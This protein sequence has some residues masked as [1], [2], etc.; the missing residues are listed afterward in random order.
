MT[1]VNTKTGK[2]IEKQ[3]FEGANPEKQLQQ[4]I[5]KHL[6][7]F[8]QCYHLKSFYKV[9]GG[10]IDCLALSE[11][12]YP[13]IIE[14]KHTKDE[15]ILNQII[16]Y[17]D[18]LQERS[19]KYEFERI[20]KENSET[21]TKMV[22]WSKIRL[23]CVAKEYTKWDISLIKHIDTEIE[24]YSYTYHKDELDIHLDP[25]INQYK[26]RR[27]F[28]AQ[29]SA[30]IKQI[31]LEDH[32]NKADKECKLLFDSLRNKIL[33]LGPNVTEG[34]APNYI[35]YVVKTTFAS[36]HVRKK[37]LIIHLR[38]NEEKFNDKKNLAK[39]ISSRKWSVTREF[40]IQ[41]VKQI[42]YA[43]SLI[44]QAYEFQE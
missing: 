30:T 14:F 16:F 31:T 35:K 3:E 12:G 19:T 38:V 13:S 18:W 9:P 7:K 2:V 32:R 24:C 27:S 37:H 40:K 29:N 5:E 41:D 23:I 44:K 22:D 8:F 4:V 6:N 21:G 20:V 34:Y 33:E 43:V 28:D 42:D 10:E 26:K 15:T 36:I 17:Y 1:R 11:D 39:D 25:I